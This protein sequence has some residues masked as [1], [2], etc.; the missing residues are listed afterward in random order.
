L[1]L[2]GDTK[3]EGLSWLPKRGVKAGNI[4]GQY[5][6][7]KELIYGP[8][9][10]SKNKLPEIP[11]VKREYIEKLL[12]GSPQQID[13]MYISPSVGQAI[14]NS[15]YSEPKWIYNT[16]VIRLTDMELEGNIIIKSDTLIHVSAFAKAKE[17]IL[18]APHIIIDSKVKGS[19][20][21][22]ASKSI[23]VGIG[24]TLEYPSSL[25][26]VREETAKTLRPNK[27]DFLGIRIEE[28]AKITGVVMYLDETKQKYSRPVVEIE[29]NS[30]VVGEVYSEGGLELKGVVFG[31]VYANKFSAQERGSIY[32]N[33]I[34]NGE[35]D[36]GKLPKRF[37]GLFTESNSKEVSKWLD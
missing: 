30:Q 15:F 11:I 35:I 9:K 21:A 22:I 17:V 14:S 2:V 20:Q 3:I 28:R 16:G 31:S 33:H 18:V 36:A 6:R 8:I 23:T 10:N 7:G 4:S 29:E 37:A 25:L 34:F 5:Y 27:D 1:V 24:A 26:V 19:F 32:Q 13:S 12:F